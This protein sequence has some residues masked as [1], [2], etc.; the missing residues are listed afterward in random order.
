MKLKYFKLYQQALHAYGATAD[1]NPFYF[2]NMLI[3]PIAREGKK[4]IGTIAL[5][6]DYN[7]PQIWFDGVKFALEAEYLKKEVET[8]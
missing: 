8:L 1:G 2:G 3:L 6:A 4:Y 5:N 7:N